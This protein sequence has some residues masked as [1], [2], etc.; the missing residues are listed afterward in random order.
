MYT[1]MR[2]GSVDELVLHGLRALRDTLPNEVEL[3]T[4][5]RISAFLFCKIFWCIYIHP[6][7]HQYFGDREGSQ[8][9]KLCFLFL[10]DQAMMTCCVHLNFICHAS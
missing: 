9:L 6:F 10:N 3:T 5:V 8:Y 2:T 1:V 7:Q 4:K